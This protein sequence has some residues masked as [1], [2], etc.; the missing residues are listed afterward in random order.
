MGG[1]MIG[2]V[3]AV[4]GVTALSLVVPMG[5]SP[6]FADQMAAPRNAQ[7]DP[8][9]LRAP[10]VTIGADAKPGITTDPVPPQGALPRPAE[11][12]DTSPGRRP[13]VGG[14]PDAPLDPAQVAPVLPVARPS[15]AP[16]PAAP[17]GDAPPEPVSETALAAPDTPRAP[18]APDIGEGSG[19]GARAEATAPATAPAGGTDAT[20]V[21]AGPQTP[22]A[23]TPETR[24]TVAADPAPAPAAAAQADQPGSDPG[25]ARADAP[26][27]PARDPL[28]PRIAALTEPSKPAAEAEIAKP[29][30]APDAAKPAAKPATKPDPAKPDPL[31]GLGLSRAGIAAAP[32]PD[33]PPIERY[34]EPFVNPEAKPLMSI[35]LIDG[36][37]SIGT[38][39]LSA[40]PYPLTFAVDP[41]LPDAAARMARHRDAGF[42]VVALVDVPAGA[43]P[44]DIEVIVGAARAAV[45]EAVALMEAVDGAVQS[46][47]ALS[48]QMTGIARAE[49]LGIVYQGNGLDTA[50]KLAV[51]EGVPAAPVFRDLDGAGQTPVVMRRFLDQA[52]FRAGVEGSVIMMGRVRPDTISALLLWGLQ[53]RASK[54]ALAPVSAVLTEA[55]GGG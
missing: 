50:Q 25:N 39:A 43:T 49:G 4:A 44:A 30:P 26:P 32:D 6:E 36:A 51:R 14:T 45:P 20:T 38:E 5:P 13:D 42:E 40:F 3:L 35:V 9:S 33:A 18:D 2:G 15:D 34:A 23:I 48:D 28:P 19:F 29:D 27:A 24:P 55:L 1:F 22:A 7:A 53:D 16:V 21:P 41:T 12:A 47:R 52:A 10:G 8:A 31:A 17:A 54:V 37:A 46:D 11:P